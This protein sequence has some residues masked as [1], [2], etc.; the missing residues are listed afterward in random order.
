M[1]L[2]RTTS[3]TY[4]IYKRILIHLLFSLHVSPFCLLRIPGSKIGEI[5]IVRIS[6]RG[7]CMFLS[8]IAL[9]ADI[10]SIREYAEC[11]PR[12]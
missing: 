4:A 3:Q 6:D 7:I 11:V 10:L 8:F 5:F 9:D 1:C 12:V 2:Q